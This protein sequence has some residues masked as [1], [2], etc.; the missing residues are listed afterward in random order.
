MSEQSL[1]IPVRR[2]TM[3]QSAHNAPFA[4]ASAR[5]GSSRSPAL[6]QPFCRHSAG[7]GTEVRPAGLCARPDP[8]KLLLRS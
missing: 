2:L 8:K 5:T 1:C 3:L 7:K 6:L 4:P